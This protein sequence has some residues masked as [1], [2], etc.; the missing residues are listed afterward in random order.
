[1]FICVPLVDAMTSLYPWHIADPHWRFGASGMIANASLLPI[2]GVLIAFVAAAVADH[3]RTIAAF[4]VVALIGA[5]LTVLWL[6]LFGLDALQTRSAVRPEMELSFAVASITAG[7]KLIL[8]A[9]ALLV[10]ALAA[11]GMLRKAAA[12]TK[13]PDSEPMIWSA[14]VRAPSKK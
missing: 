3:R 12:Q 10:L 9:V 4:R 5:I 11:R 1:M 8:D 6:A 13:R 14:D 7:V 2:G